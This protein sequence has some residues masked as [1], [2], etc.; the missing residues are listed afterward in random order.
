MHPTESGRRA[1]VD[2]ALRIDKNS[3]LPNRLAG[4]TCTPSLLGRHLRV[5]IGVSDRRSRCSSPMISPRAFPTVRD[6]TT[7]A[8]ETLIYD[9]TRASGI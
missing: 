3:S 7:C 5:C 9:A 8:Q 2:L 4:E 6:E 1:G